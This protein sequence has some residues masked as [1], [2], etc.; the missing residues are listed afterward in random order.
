MG[1]WHVT[2]SMQLFEQGGADGKPHEG[3]KKSLRPCG[4]SYEVGL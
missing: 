2:A 1:C 3:G 4:A